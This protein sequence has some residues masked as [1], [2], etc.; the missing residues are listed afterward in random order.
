MA[1]R[2]ID[3][4]EAEAE[5][6][7]WDF[8]PFCDQSEDP[9]GKGARRMSGHLDPEPLTSRGAKG[10]SSGL[11]DIVGGRIAGTSFRGEARPYSARSALMPPAPDPGP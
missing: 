1:I 10:S 5:A 11:P 8:D 7:R 3:P 4:A 6:F 2:R 9:Q